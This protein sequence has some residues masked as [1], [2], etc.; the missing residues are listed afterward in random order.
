[1]R[2]TEGEEMEKIDVAVIGA[3]VLGCA[4]A[5]EL[6]RYKLDVA[7]L[8]RAHDVGEGSSKANSGIVH[9]GFHP[10]GGSLKGLSCVQ[11]NARIGKIARQLEIPYVNTG[12]LMV[13]FNDEGIG[14][15]REKAQRARENG[16]GELPIVDG[17]AARVL[18]PRLSARV[19][20]ALV[21]PTTGV[22][23]PFDLVWG[24][25]Q[26]ACA[27]GVS[28]VFNAP[29][30]RIEKARGGASAGYRYVLHLEGGAS[31][32][33][34]F[35]VNMGGDGAA[36]LDAQ[37]H[38]ADYRVRPRLGEYV[39]F[40]K[41]DP[42]R[43]I[44]HVIYQAAETDEGGTLL[45]PTVEGNLLAGPTSRNVRGF[46]DTAST[47]EGIRHVLGV[48]R[49]LI[50]DLDETQ[51]I[52][53]F[54]GVRTNIVNVSK[55]LKDFVVRVSAPGFVSA[56][57]IKN[58]GLTSSPV[59]ARRAVDLLEG[60]GLRLVPDERFTPTRRRHVPFLQRASEEQ[61]ALLRQDAA[62]GNVLCRC[63]GI[64]E[65]DVRAVMRGPL[66]PS[67]LAGMKRRL[68]CGMGRCQGAFCM[69][70]VVQVMADELGVEPCDVPAGEHGGRFVVRSVK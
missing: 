54:A 49:K 62:Y 47:P 64:T 6:S 69:P 28:F 41:Q 66:P 52:S 58:P 19:K 15:L 59:L 26:N 8:E 32:A 5:R 31:V 33:A 24:L 38:P 46:S 25:A 7:V 36:L 67:T 2:E 42:A 13:A 61:R 48:A 40:D 43:A 53:N 60:E 12:G 22:I 51:V 55:E 56:L 50:P 70:R 14:K 9:A 57:G 30:D 45:A 65:G 17:Y 63:E 68:R 16:A 21:A 18:E 23:T 35:V 44:T 37:V 3:G 4:V 39:V 1:M 10:R 29:V 20:A 27:N 11:G 34:R